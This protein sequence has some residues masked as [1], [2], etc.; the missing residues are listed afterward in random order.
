FAILGPVVMS[1]QGS[2]QNRKSPAQALTVIITSLNRRRSSWLAHCRPFSPSDERRDQTDEKLNFTGNGK[3]P[4][5]AG[6]VLPIAFIA[7][8][9]SIRFATTFG[10]ETTTTWEAPFILMRRP[11]SFQNMQCSSCLTL[12][13]AH[14]S[15]HADCSR[16]VFHVIT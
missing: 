14:L 8:L 11:V 12:P 6:L 9:F 15:D 2:E 10:L 7:Q 1:H 5:C 3:R 16:I 4:A 13:E